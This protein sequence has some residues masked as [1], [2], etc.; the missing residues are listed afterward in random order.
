MFGKQNYTG[1]IIVEELDMARR[2]RDWN[3]RLAEDLRDLDYARAFI[4]ASLDD[5]IDIRLVLA[6][7]IRA[8]GV[9]EFSAMAQMA[10]SNVL[11]SLREKH[12]PTFATV[13]RLLRPFGLRLTVS[14]VNH[15][16][17]KRIAA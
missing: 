5:G 1:E 10:S 9:K 2:S 13:N 17:K 11:R 14:E 15:G 12:N 7:V 3:E 8:Y 16:R 6:K 4:L